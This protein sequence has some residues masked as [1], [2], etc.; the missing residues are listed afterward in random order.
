MDNVSLNVFTVVIR[1][2][3]GLLDI[4][5]LINGKL[6]RPKIN[7]LYSLIDYINKDIINSKLKDIIEKLPLDKS[8][9]ANNS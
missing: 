3:N 1:S 4:I 8:N 2:K 9:L 7:K 6:I 5:S